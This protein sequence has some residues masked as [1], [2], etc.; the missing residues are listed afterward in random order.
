MSLKRQIREERNLNHKIQSEFDDY[1]KTVKATNFDELKVQI[2]AYQNECV[3]LRRLL[4]KEIKDGNKNF[5]KLS[6]EIYNI[7]Q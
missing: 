7:L 5:L 2:A 4:K 1:K 3:R 6:A